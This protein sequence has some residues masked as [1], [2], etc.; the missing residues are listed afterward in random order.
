MDGASFTRQA[1]ASRGSGLLP[2]MILGGIVAAIAGGIQYFLVFR[3]PA[4]VAGTAAALAIAAFLV[5]R[6]SLETFA[7]SIR[8]Y[9]GLASAEAGT[10]YKEV[11]G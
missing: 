7:A 5:T 6:A 4:I 10:L 1:D 11:D 3:S 8:F 9:L 2:M